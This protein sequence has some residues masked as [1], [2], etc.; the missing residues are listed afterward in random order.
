MDGTHKLERNNMLHI[1]NHLTQQEEIKQCYVHYKKM[2]DDLLEDSVRTDVAYLTYLQ[3]QVI[4]YKTEFE[5]Y[6]S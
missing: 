5:K 1:E 3:K 2:L 6:D 4:Y